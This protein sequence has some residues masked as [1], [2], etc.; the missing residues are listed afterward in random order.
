M[1]KTRVFRARHP[2]LT[3]AAI[4]PIAILTPAKGEDQTRG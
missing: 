4:A 3:V 2:T 1:I